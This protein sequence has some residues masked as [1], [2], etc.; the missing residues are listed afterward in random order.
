ML[1]IDG[2]D[3]E[4]LL[5]SDV[6]SERLEVGDDQ[7]GLP[8]VDQVLQAG[9]TLRRLR[10]CDQVLGDRALIADAIVY[11]GEAETVNLSDVE[12]R[13][14]ILQAAVERGDVNGVSLATR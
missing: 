4:A 5:V 1:V 6:T 14:E 7:V 11:V 2:N 3:R 9:Q 12:V 13:L 10:N 8:F